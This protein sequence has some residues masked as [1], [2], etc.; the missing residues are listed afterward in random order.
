[1]D[2]AKKKSPPRLS[3]QVTPKMVKRLQKVFAAELAARP[4]LS[5]SD[6]ER[7][8]MDAGLRTLE[9][10]GTNDGAEES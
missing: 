7:E 5:L 6:I 10:R 4:F 9:P 2:P 8:V 3:F 1:M